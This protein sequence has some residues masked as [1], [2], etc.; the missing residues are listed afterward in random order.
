MTPKEYLD[1]LRQKTR[2]QLIRECL[3]LNA[4]QENYRVRLTQAQQT[5]EALQGRPVRS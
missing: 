4:R 2:D 5:I 3:I 1:E